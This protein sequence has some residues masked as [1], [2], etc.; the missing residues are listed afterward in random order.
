MK[1]V[2]LSDNLYKKVE[3]ASKIHGMEVDD[4]VNKVIN[5]GIELL[6]E[7]NILELY[8]NRKITLQKAAEM[9][10]LDIWDI[11]DKLKKADIHIDYTMES[12]IEDLK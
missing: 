8:R 5:E 3:K 6:N 11:I 2:K 12:L 4:L 9:L 1:V 7:K 10:S